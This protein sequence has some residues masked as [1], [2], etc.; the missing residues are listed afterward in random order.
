[1][2]GRVDGEEEA[3]LSRRSD[4][5]PSARAFSEVGTDSRKLLVVRRPVYQEAAVRA[6]WVRIE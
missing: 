6:L 1:M 3:G 5:K 2:R 4:G